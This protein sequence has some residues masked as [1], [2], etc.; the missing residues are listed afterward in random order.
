L[1]VDRCRLVEA[2]RPDATFKRR[3]A[4]LNRYLI[5]DATLVPIFEGADD[6]C[7]G[8]RQ[9][10]RANH[11]EKQSGNAESRGVN[12]RRYLVIAKGEAE[13]PGRLVQMQLK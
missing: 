4:I 3:H 2:D 10:L 11:Q 5:E 12:Q 8:C 7:L 6:A 13:K 9:L 1:L